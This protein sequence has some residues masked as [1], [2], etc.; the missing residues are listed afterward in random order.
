MNLLLK[1]LVVTKEVNLLRLTIF[2]KK[3]VKL[4]CTIVM[5][6]TCPI[7]Y[8]IFKPL[9]KHLIYFVERTLKTFILRCQINSTKKLFIKHSLY[10]V[11]LI[12]SLQ[13]AKIYL[14]CVVKNHIF[15]SPTQSKNKLG[16]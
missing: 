1:T 4:G 12:L 13:Q 5:L 14:H 8:M 15:L 16:N 2:S 10:F 11:S 6:V 3:M 7:Y 9:V